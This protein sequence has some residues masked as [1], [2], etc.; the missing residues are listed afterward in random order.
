MDEFLATAI[1]E[2]KKGLADG[3]IPHCLGARY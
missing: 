3:G 1:D 2:A